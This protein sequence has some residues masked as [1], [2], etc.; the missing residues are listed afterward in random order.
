M[1]KQNILVIKHGSLGD[2]ILATGAFKLIR[3]SHPNANIIMLTQTYY[4]SLARK[5]GW[6]DEVLLDDRLPYYKFLPNLRVIRELRRYRY[7][8]VYDLQCSSRTNF[9]HF[10][11]KSRIYNWY[12]RARFCSHFVEFN[13]EAHSVELAHDIIKASGINEMPEPDVRMLRTNSMMSK[14]KSFGRFV[15][16]TPGS[17]AKHLYKR[18][19]PEGYAK[20]IDFLASKKINSI[21][22]GTEIDRETINANNGLVSYQ[23]MHFN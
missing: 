15:I 17:S 20:I 1:K 23:I 22:I 7:D 11:L 9:Y 12:G 6:F 14:I 8:H 18:W 4:A 10:L 3:K 2:W 16:F 13:P 21:L 5:S 19:T